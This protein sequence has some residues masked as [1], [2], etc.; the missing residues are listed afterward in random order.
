ME[1]APL[2]IDTRPQ[3]GTIGPG[4]GGLGQYDEIEARRVFGMGAEA[5][6]HDPL[7]RVAPR[8]EGDLATTDGESKPA[9]RQ[10]IRP[11]QHGYPRIT[12][13]GRPLENGAELGRAQQAL[14]A[15]EAGHAEWDADGRPAITASDDDGPWRAVL[16]ARRAKGRH[17]LTP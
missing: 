13:P 10:V 4:G 17:R 2:A 1:D 12:C 14:M 6:A 11:G 16:K 7:E 15:R 5:L 3:L 8:G 9:V